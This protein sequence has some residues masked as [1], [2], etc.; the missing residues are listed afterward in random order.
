MRQQAWDR[1]LLHYHANE[2][3]DESPV[4]EGFRRGHLCFRRIYIRPVDAKSAFQASDDEAMGRLSKI[5]ERAP[6]KPSL[7][8]SILPLGTSPVVTKS[9]LHQIST[10]TQSESYP[11]QDLPRQDDDHTRPSLPWSKTPLRLISAP[12]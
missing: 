1:R 12:L 4:A 5:Q 8:L 10:S 2:L 11:L 6:P 3:Y 7:S 9:F